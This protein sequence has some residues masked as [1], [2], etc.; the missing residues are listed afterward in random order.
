MGYF[1]WTWPPCFASAKTNMME[2]CA[3]PWASH[4]QPLW[5]GWP[6]VFGDL[7]TEVSS[8]LWRV[9][10][11]LHDWLRYWQLTIHMN[12]TDWTF[13]TDTVH[14]DRGG[15]FS[16]SCP[17]TLRAVPIM[18][19]VQYRTQNTIQSGPRHKSFIVGTI[20]WKIS[21]DTHDMESLRQIDD[22][23]WPHFLAYACFSAIR[24][25]LQTNTPPAECG[26]NL[27]CGLCE[28]QTLDYLPTGF[29]ST[30]S[31]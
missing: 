28:K 2:G 3:P 21:T 11:V 19:I 22:S 6:S 9:R 7:I 26:L 17:P 27:V 5:K 15:V 20:G 16:C 30:E 31:W 4:G 13:N 18:V 29:L 1:P 12:P 25:I 24:T 8:Y 14:K 23:Q 10:R